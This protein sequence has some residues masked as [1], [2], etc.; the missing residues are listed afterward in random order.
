MPTPKNT[1]LAKQQLQHLR[2]LAHEIKPIIII[3]NK[4]LTENVMEEIKLALEHHELIKVRV[5]AGDRDARA[6]MIEQIINEC[7]AEKVITVG[8]IVG[9]YKQ[10]KEPK[11]IL[12]K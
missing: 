1:N 2:Q 4:G 8:H 6:K 9:L 7:V 5:N 11:I 10:A 12:P 3:G